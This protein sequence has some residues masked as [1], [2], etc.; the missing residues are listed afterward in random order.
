M[1][2]LKYTLI[3]ISYDLKIGQISNFSWGLEAPE[4]LVAS[5][6]AITR[7][8]DRFHFG[9]RILE[10]IVG[11]CERASTFVHALGPQKYRSAKAQKS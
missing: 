10:S 5:A 7:I 2:V 3:P 1:I 9:R 11:G 8:F 4:P 6:R